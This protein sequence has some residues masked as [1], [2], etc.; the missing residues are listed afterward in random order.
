MYSFYGGQEGRTYHIVKSYPSVAAMDAD[1]S[2]NNTQV[3][4]HQY[5]LIDTTIEEMTI[6]GITYTGKG[7]NNSEN[8]LLY[9]RGFSGSEKVGN[10]RGQTGNT[11]D[12]IFDNNLQFTE[13]KKTYEPELHDA[14][15]TDGN[16]INSTYQIFESVTGQP[17]T[18]G[19]KLSVPY[20][21]ITAQASTV[22]YNANVNASVTA[23]EPY[24][25][26]V[27]FDIPNGVPGTQIDTATIQNKGTPTQNI[28]F[29]GTSY[30]KGDQS[31]T[32]GSYSFWV[33]Y[34]TI[35]SITPSS[36]DN[37]LTVTYDGDSTSSSQQNIGPLTYTANVRGI[38]E[39]LPTSAQ[40]GLIVYKQDGKNYICIWDENSTASNKWTKVQNLSD[41]VEPNKVIVNMT[42]SSSPSSIN[43]EN[44]TQSGY[45]LLDGGYALNIKTFIPRNFGALTQVGSGDVPQLIV[46]GG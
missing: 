30:A 9:R 32:G 44:T 21:H 19:I 15:E 3:M 5:V 11:A 45:S 22:E 28:T 6:N 8:G 27:N 1:F 20:P 12:I 7:I 43:I 16:K 39:T 34:R 10:I 17:T 13:D 36:L 42:N 2:S 29:T 37:K 38:F 24:R 31:T 40:S 4:Y 35:K 14:S 25:Y 26:N 18:F 23:N 41:T 46:V 33:P